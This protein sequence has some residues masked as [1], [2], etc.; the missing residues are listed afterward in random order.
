MHRQTNAAGRDLIKSFEGLRLKAYLCPAGVATVGWGHTGPDVV[1]G[2]IITR[3]RAE[4]LLAIDLARFERFV[5]ERCSPATDNQF[6]ALVS[7][8]YNVGEGALKTSTLRRMHLEGDYAGAARQFARWNK[9]AGRVLAG[10]TKRRS[11]EA[12]LYGKPE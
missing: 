7:F 9:A 3:E 2:Q 8:A 12:A 5:E 6:A 1:V 11:A 10:L 4:E